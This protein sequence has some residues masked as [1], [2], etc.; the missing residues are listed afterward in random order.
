VGPTVAQNCEGDKAAPFVVNFQMIDT[1][2]DGKISADE[3]T[4]GCAQ[5]W[6]QE[7]DASTVK[8]MKGSHQ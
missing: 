5:G 8:D 1:D 4:A 3:F 2:K 6:I 7:P